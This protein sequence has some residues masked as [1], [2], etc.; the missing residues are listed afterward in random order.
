M[1]VA[2]RGLVSVSLLAAWLGVS[3][4]GA[5]VDAQARAR[6]SVVVGE[7]GARQGGPGA[8]E[9]LS[10]AMRTVL[11][12]H[13]NVTLAEDRRSAR[14]LVSGSVVE[15]DE[16]EVGDEHEVRCRVSIIVADARGG[17]V[18]AMLEGRAGVRGGDDEA[19]LRRT[20]VRG[21]VQSALR[22]LG[23]RVR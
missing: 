12:S 23:D 6:T 20:A 4:V 15:L 11:A 7:M 14:F 13:P 8:Q 9:D 21:A 2:R 22:S 18:R 1:R 17:S 5:D 3:L 19:S 10:S 16:H